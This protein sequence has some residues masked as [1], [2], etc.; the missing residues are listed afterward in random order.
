MPRNSF[1]ELEKI[2]MEN[3]TAPL[4]KIKSNV[5]HSLGVFQ[6]A[7]EITQLFIPKIVELLFSIF[8]GDDTRK[9]DPNSKYPNLRG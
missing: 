6:F 1:K 3:V 9:A 7:G 5:N 2:E 8:G 4:D